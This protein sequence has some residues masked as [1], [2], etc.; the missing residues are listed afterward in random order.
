MASIHLPL[1]CTPPP[2]GF[3]LT[4]PAC[5]TFT[6]GWT[7][8][9][10][11]N[12]V[13][14]CNITGAEFLSGATANLLAAITTGTNAPNISA[15][16]SASPILPRSPRWSRGWSAMS[17]QSLAGPPLVSPLAAFATF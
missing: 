9:Q 10:V 4:S 7:M 12:H 1:A 11:V 13:F 3:I 16:S 8:P 17:A 6:N 14:G 2:P 5:H 15:P